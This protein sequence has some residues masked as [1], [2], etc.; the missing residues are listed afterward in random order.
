MTDAHLE[1]PILHGR[2]L[3]L[4]EW[5]SSDVATIQ[6]ASH[7]PFIPV[8][9]TVP[10]TSGE[11][12]ALAFIAR[13][14]DRLRARAGYVFAI[15][16]ASDRAVGHIG[17]FFSAGARAFVGYWITPS[18]RRRGY[19]SEALGILTS[20]AKQHADL[21]RLEL[22]VE[23]WNSGS[24]LAAELAGYKREGLLRAWERIDGKPC[25]MYMYAQLTAN[26]SEKQ[27]VQT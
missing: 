23:P 11:P 20:W 27:D 17:L 22:Y 26:A 24:W 18:Q 5:R 21:D 1:L 13:Q 2:R 25:D 7:D 19:A 10:S 12:E 8:T 16:D 3:L 15:A 6:E 9:T 14:Q 4:R